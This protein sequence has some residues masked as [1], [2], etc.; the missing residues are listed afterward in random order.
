MTSITFL[1]EVPKPARQIGLDVLSGELWVTWN[2][3]KTSTQKECLRKAGIEPHKF[4][5]AI[6]WWG[7]EE[8]LPPKEL[9]TLLRSIKPHI[10]ILL[11]NYK[12]VKDAAGN[13]KVDLPDG[14]AS[15]AYYA[16]CDLCDSTYL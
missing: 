15:A 12:L 6:L 7:I 14:P 2:Q 3:R 4:D 16:I 8:V 13:N 1:G 10:Q 5:W 9:K 11:D